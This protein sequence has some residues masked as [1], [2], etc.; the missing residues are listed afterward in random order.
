M[1]STPSEFCNMVRKIYIYTCD[2]AKRLSPKVKL[3]VLKGEGISK[4]NADATR[5]GFDDGA[6]A[7]VASDKDC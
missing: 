3:P 2:E 5:N 6:Y 7:S 4:N 1:L